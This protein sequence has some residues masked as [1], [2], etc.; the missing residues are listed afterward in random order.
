MVMY[1]EGGLV[2]EYGHIDEGGF[3]ESG[4]DKGGLPAEFQ[5]EPT[6]NHG[7]QEWTLPRRMTTQGRLGRR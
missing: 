3:D 2:N 6:R 5:Q 1:D 7:G 4:L